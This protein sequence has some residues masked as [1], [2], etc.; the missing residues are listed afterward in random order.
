[1]YFP[2]D[3]MNSLRGFITCTKKLP[4][5]HPKWKKKETG[6]RNDQID[7]DIKCMQK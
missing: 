3:E 1:M 4:E 7:K 6:S 5:I 2:L